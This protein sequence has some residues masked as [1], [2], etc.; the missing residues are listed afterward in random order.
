LR[1]ATQVDPGTTTGIG[2]TGL[3]ALVGWFATIAGGGQLRSH[4]P[5]ALAEAAAITTN[6]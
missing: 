1:A 2:T 5:I 3:D 6:P 4:V